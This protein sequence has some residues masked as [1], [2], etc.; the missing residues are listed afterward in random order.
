MKKVLTVLTLNRI[1][2]E[3]PKGSNSQ[4]L[5]SRK[6][7]L[8]W[9]QNFEYGEN[10]SVSSNPSQDEITIKIKLREGEH[11]VA[12]DAQGVAKQKEI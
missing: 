6:G 12:F 7:N 9:I 8:F 3:V 5:G 4:I 1:E 10:V 11:L 2:S